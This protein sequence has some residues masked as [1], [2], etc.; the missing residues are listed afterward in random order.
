MSVIL[1]LIADLA[2]DVLS[3]RHLWP[4]LAVMAL[5]VG[6]TLTGITARM[7]VWL[8]DTLFGRSERAATS[9]GAGI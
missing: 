6:S 2:R 9:R 7:L 8:E 1:S 3:S 4:V 5:V